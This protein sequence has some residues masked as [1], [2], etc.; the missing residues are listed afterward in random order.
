MSRIPALT[1]DQASPA[2]RQLFQGVS[3]R[4]GRV[5]NLYRVAANQ[6]KV[7]E[8]LLGFGAT[9]DK[10]S[11]S[12]A[13]I[14]AIALT[15]AGLNGCDYC[16][17]AHTAISALQKRDPIE[18]AANLTGQSSDPRTAAI[19]ALATA[20]IST[21][22]KISDAAVTAARQAGLSDADVVETV[23]QVVKQIFTNYLNQV[24]E[25]D[26][27]FPAVSARAA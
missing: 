20:I 5:P 21:R 18:V 4:L 15:S 14:E 2:A 23:G 26:L 19:L 25:T 3:S 6:P 12:P 10:A 11:F 24:A 7:L 16:A 22:G 27:D 8:A 13:Q 1:D 17:S 9:L